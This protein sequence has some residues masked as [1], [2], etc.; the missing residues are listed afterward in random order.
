MNESAEYVLSNCRENDVKF[1]RLWFTDITGA[2]KSF[3]ITVEEVEKLAAAGRPVPPAVETGSWQTSEQSHAVSS[4]TERS[5]ATTN[6][7]Y[8]THD[9]R[10]GARNLSRVGRQVLSR[11]DRSTL[12]E[13]ACARLR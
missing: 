8:E 5:S 9:L 11:R 4:G 12:A 13:V 7:V 10:A 6:T 3:A 1:V 2:L